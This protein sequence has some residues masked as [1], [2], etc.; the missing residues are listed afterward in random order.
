ME[1]AATT[2]RGGKWWEVGGGGTVWDSMAYDPDLNL[3]Y[4]GVGNGSPWNRYIRS[5]G[6]GDNLFLSSI[7][8][9]NPDDGTKV[10]H[11]QTTP[12]DTWDYTAVQHMILADIELQ[13]ETRK[14]IMQ[15]PKTGFSMCWIGK[16]E[17]SCLQR[18]M[19]PSPGRPM[20]IQKQGDQW[21]IPRLTTPMR[22]SESNRVL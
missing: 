7:V 12:G 13:G 3:L 18:L 5:P 11:Y 2:W 17:N 8:A 4:I 1:E 19:C 14:V 6:G 21:K 15:A 10:W 20:S 9:I 16:P 22:K